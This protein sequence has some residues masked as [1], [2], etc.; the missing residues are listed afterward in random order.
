MRINRILLSLLAI[1]LLASGSCF[2][3]IRVLDDLG[4]V[5]ELPAPARRIVSLAPHNTENLFTAGAGDLIVGTV[6]YSDFP[7]QALS[8]SRVGNYKQINFEA[9]L[10]LKPDLIIAW[11]SGNLE[12]TGRRLETLGLPVFYSEPSTFEL[13]IS[14][15]ERFGQLSNRRSQ[16]QKAAE[17]MREVLNTLNREYAAK[18]PVSVFY[19]VWYQ[20]LITLNGQHAVSRALEV[21]GGVNVFADEPTIAPRINVESVISRNPQLIL[22]AGHDNTQ[23][24]SWLDNWEKWPAIRAVSDQQ[25]KF[26]NPDIINRPT[27]R[28]LEATREICKL[29]DSARPQVRLTNRAD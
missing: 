26:V 27:R 21:C 11:S 10:G 13:I 7:E 28:F 18:S 24:S 19:Q 16:A 22:L 6:D 1:L 29:I 4:R 12:E 5:V 17:E 14:N 2:A 9:V 15:V 20:P 25:V 8:I 23:T 3:E